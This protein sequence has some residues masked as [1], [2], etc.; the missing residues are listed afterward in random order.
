MIR[1][2]RTLHFLLLVFCMSIFHS[3]IAEAFDVPAA[4]DKLAD[5]PLAKLQPWV[6][7]WEVNTEWEGGRKLWA[8]NEYKI[9]LGGRFLIA[10][11]YTK[12]SDGKV[13]HR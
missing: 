8:R 4:V 12:D 6:G 10:D 9:G 7:N 13:Y 11:T 5:G 1:L 3:Q 2:P